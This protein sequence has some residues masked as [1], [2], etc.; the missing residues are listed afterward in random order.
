MLAVTK[1]I[2]SR[3]YGR[4]LEQSPTLADDIKADSGILHVTDSAL[5]PKPTVT[6]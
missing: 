4:F 2:N 1:R 5:P 3:R 6:N